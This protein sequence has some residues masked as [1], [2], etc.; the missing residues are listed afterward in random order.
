MHLG[1]RDKSAVKY[2][3]YAFLK[4]GWFGKIILKYKGL[5]TRVNFLSSIPLFKFF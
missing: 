1:E 2:S 5:V 3:N 4:E